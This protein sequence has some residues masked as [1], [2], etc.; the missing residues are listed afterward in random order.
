MKVTEL[1]TKLQS[2]PPNADVLCYTEDKNLQ[3]KGYMFRILDIEDVS[4]SE[5][6]KIRMPDTQP[7]LKFEKSESS[8]PHV[9]I[10]VTSDF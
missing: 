10:S 1:I 2:L 5:A 8:E 4:L 7:S 3:A 6:A 9:I